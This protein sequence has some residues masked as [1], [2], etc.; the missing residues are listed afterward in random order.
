MHKLRNGF[1]KN[2]VPY[3]LSSIK[4]KSFFDEISYKQI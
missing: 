2:R 1:H 4:T 3:A